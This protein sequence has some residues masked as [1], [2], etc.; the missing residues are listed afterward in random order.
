M[1][2]ERVGMIIYY[3][4]FMNARYLFIGISMALCLLTWGCGYR[5]AGGGSLPAGVKRV[6]V[7]IFENRTSE[8]GLENTVTQSLIYE[9]T[10]NE[11]YSSKER[12]EAVLSGVIRSMKTGSISRV[13]EQVTVER[14]VVLTLDLKLVHKDGRVIWAR[15]GISESEAFDVTSDELATERN[16]REALS[17]LA[18]RLG[19]RLYNQLTEDF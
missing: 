10:R 5:F 8:I 1:N 13:S 17:K 7:S 11:V 19:E 4:K 3:N 9:F 2:P 18:E 6:F 12:A 15:N 14:R 16:L